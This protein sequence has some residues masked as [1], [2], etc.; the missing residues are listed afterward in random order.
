MRL[1]LKQHNN[2]IDCPLSLLSVHKPQTCISVTAIITDLQSLPQPFQDSWIAY[3][4]FL[5]IQ[6]YKFHGLI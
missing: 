6:D 1:R 4:W 5:L 2:A 3:K